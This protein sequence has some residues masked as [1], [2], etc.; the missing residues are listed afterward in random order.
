MMSKPIEQNG[1]VK[2]HELYEKEKQTSNVRDLSIASYVNNPRV[3]SDS[4]DK[5]VQCSSAKT[6]FKQT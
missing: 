3:V 5:D 4:M 2:G 6:L 1:S